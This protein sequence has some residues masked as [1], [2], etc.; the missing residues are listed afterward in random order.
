MSS[1]WVR[2]HGMK[3]E[4]EFVR[5]GPSMAG[6][7]DYTCPAR[8]A[9]KARPDVRPANWP[10]WPKPALETFALGPV[11]TLLDRIEFGG[12]PIDEIMSAPVNGEHPSH[13]GL[14]NFTRHAVA[15][16]VSIGH[17]GLN[18][19]EE[20]W[21]LQWT[22]E[23]PELFRELYAWGRRYQ[24]PDGRS[25]EFRFLCHGSAGARPREDAA[26][27]IAAYCASFGM[28]APWPQPWSDRFAVAGPSAPVEH[29]R[30][31]EVGLL[32][33][34]QVTLFDGTPEQA[35]L[36]FEGGGLEEVRRIVAG[37]PAIAGSSCA[38]CK[39]LTAC[40]E[41]RKAPGLLGIR[42]G[43]APIRSVSV[44]DLRYHRDCPAQMHMR[45]TL[46]LPKQG[47]YGPDAVRGQAIHQLLETVHSNPAKAPCSSSSVEVDARGWTAGKFTV[48][49]EQAGLG[50]AMLSH[51]PDTCPLA[52][53]VGVQ[54][55]RLEPGLAFWDTAAN[56]IVLA[57]PDLL[58]RERQSWIWR[59]TKSTEKER[60]YHDDLLDEFPQLALGLL[61]LS[62]GLLGGEVAGA[63]VELEVLRPGRA[64]VYQEDPTDP[65][66]VAKAAQVIASMALPWHADRRY[67]ANAS[68]RVCQR[69]PVSLWCTDFAGS[70]RAAALDEGEFY[71]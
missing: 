70:E 43:R 56:A 27:A 46:H 63:R 1:A 29:V 18:P 33:G 34:S 55:A 61:I 9:A 65:E 53:P 8:I 40:P 11:K 5:V 45:S 66:R 58:Y 60:W 31:V 23:D 35:S 51:H 24:S 21:V 38:D 22:S 6:E 42:A 30:I 41:P 62:R 57:K 59:E 52:S 54:E 26:V 12:L 50:A 25:R 15:S 36:L 19:V 69:C 3:G 64:E 67:V 7:D 16:Y 71:E 37:G 10:N 44:S 49:G 28:R 14:E 2:P 17:E 20:Y 68:E 48:E 47:E 39:L 13:P 32:D 4:P